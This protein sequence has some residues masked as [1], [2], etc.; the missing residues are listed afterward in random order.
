MI[1]RDENSKNG[2]HNSNAY[3]D[4]LRE[5]FDLCMRQNH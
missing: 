5:G 3:N 2:K 4:H 1:L